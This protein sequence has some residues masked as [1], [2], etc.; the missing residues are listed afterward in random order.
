MFVCIYSVFV[1]SCLQVAA[2]RR[3]DPPSKESYRLC[4]RDQESEKERPRPNKG[5]Y[6]HRHIVE[7]YAH[8]INQG[9]QG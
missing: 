9:R 4:K 1:L 5:V 3:I 7:F 8:C 6:S 2:L